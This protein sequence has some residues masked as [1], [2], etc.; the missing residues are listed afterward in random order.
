MIWTCAQA[1]EEMLD[2]HSLADVW[3]GARIID[4]WPYVVGQR[5]AEG[6]RPFL[7]K[8][9]L[10]RRGL[11]TVAV[12]SSVWMQEMSFL[13]IAGRLNHEL[14]RSLV[15]TVRFEVREVLPT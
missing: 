1:L 2:H 7:E 9:D 10:H 13:D 4:A 12:K 6:A 15:Q 14:G 5:Y 8:S 11:L 3:W